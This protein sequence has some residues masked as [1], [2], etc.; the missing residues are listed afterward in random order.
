MEDQR[1]NSLTRYGLGGGGRGYPPALRAAEG[2]LLA[3]RSP[4]DDD[5]ESLTTVASDL[6]ASVARF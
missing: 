6:T 5:N 2:Y 1:R 4:S 3:P